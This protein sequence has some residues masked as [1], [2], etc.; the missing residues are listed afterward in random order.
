MR[1]ALNGVSALLLLAGSLLAQQAITTRT[2]V[3]NAVPQGAQRQGGD[4]GRAPNT[5]P[6]I[7]EL[8]QTY[9]RLAGSLRVV[10]VG[11]VKN[12]A[13]LE[14]PEFATLKL[15][16]QAA[17]AD[18]GQIMA[19]PVPASSGPQ[20][21]G[22]LQSTRL[23]A[24]TAP[25]QQK[26][27]GVLASNLNAIC[28]PNVTSIAA[29][30]QK[31]TGVVFSPTSMYNIYTIAGCGFGTTPGRVYLQGGPGAFPAH[32]GRLNFVVRTW[33]DR[34]IVATLDPSIAGELDQNNLTLVVETSS[35][36]GQS[37]PHSFFAVRS[38][39]VAIAALPKSAYCASQ[40]ASLYSCP[41]GLA[42]IGGAIIAPCGEWGLTDCSIEVFRQN[43][44]ASPT[45]PQVDQ[46]KPKLKPGFVLSSIVVQIGTIANDLG[47][48]D[49]RTLNPTI[50]GN[51]VF[52]RMPVTRDAM[53]G[54]DSLYGVK[55]FV[56]GPAG[57]NPLVDGQ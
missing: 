22:M 21:R 51:Q 2:T 35:G 41:A 46:Y 11:E 1:R 23:T 47:K 34:G 6:G 40:P 18:V 19:A 30:N 12:P 9:A 8:N 53:G 43:P 36:K 14:L 5:S 38:Q 55:F 42:P 13:A 7:G 45:Q 54:Y 24:V 28:M 15:Q 57:V 26:S 20:N 29:V 48:V 33:T 37:G 32:N 56:I 3:P 44:F 10:N 25:P 50:N 31:K 4:P 27:P 16:K 49:I 17:D 39:P 52:L